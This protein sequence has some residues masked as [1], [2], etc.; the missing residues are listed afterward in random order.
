MILFRLAIFLHFIGLI[1]FILM[2]H[3]LNDFRLK[4]GFFVFLKFIVDLQIFWI[5]FLILL[6]EYFIFILN[7]F[8]INFFRNFW[9]LCI[10]KYIVSVKRYWILVENIV[11]L[12]WFWYFLFGNEAL[13]FF[14]L[15]LFLQKFL[16]IENFFEIPRLL[17]P[18]ELSILI[19][20]NKWCLVL[21]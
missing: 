20:T 9:V 13:L 3:I 10:F 2:I 6:F 16:N 1:I 17:W 21:V 12:C 15:F 7:L 5:E 11:Y 8:L 19:W 14:N 18:N 4:L